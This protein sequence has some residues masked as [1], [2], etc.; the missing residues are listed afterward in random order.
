M[1]TIV[2]LDFVSVFVCL[3][4]CLFIYLFT[5]SFGI[6]MKYRG[7]KIIKSN[8]QIGVRG[9]LGNGE[10]LFLEAFK[11]KENQYLCQ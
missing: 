11:H 7:T 1:H 4:V 6:L 2:C 5:Y 3:F 10:F 8:S 9:K